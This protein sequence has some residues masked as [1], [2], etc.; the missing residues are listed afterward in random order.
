MSGQVA[1]LVATD[2]GVSG[3]VVD[4]QPEHVLALGEEE[5]VC[6]SELPISSL[7][8]YADNDLLGLHHILVRLVAEDDRE[9]MWDAF[10]ALNADD[11]MA[12][13]SSLIETYTE[14]PT[15]PASPSRAGS[16]RTSRR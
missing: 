4:P 10:E 7:I 3:E 6:G 11:A 14:R 16:R 5:F 15:K 12:A 8:R 2:D 1:T 9:R 13:I